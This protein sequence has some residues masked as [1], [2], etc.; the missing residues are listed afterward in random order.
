MKYVKLLLL[1]LAASS[2]KAQVRFQEIPL[3]EALKQASV[4]GKIVFAQFVSSSCEQCNEVADKAFANPQLGNLVKEKCIAIKIEPEAKDR[5][6]FMETYGIDQSMGSFFIT[7]DGDL[8]HRVNSTSSN[9]K[10]YTTAIET[11]YNKFVEGRLSLKELDNLWASTTND[12][13]LMEM[14]LKRR[15]ELSLPMD[16]L[17]EVYVSRLPADSL[18]SVRTLQFIAKQAPLLTSNASK[19]LRKDTSLFKEAWYSMSLQERVGIN[20]RIVSKTKKLAIA[21]KNI[22]IAL[23]AAN[24]ARSVQENPSSGGK[25]VFDFH[26]L[27]YYRG[28]K[29]KENLLVNAVAYCDNY[30]MKATV[31]QVRMMDSMY[32]RK[33]F[34]KA[35]A[36]TVRKGSGNMTIRKTAMVSLSPIAQDYCN[37]LGH[38]AE[39]IYNYSDDVELLKKAQVYAEKAVLIYENP[40]AI[41]VYAKILYANKQVEEA[42]KWEQK[43]IDILQQRQYTGN[44][45]IKVLQKMKDGASLK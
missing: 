5:N 7:A 44:R 33:L 42:M 6:G 36:D 29:D 2:A 8:V 31:Q 15:T 14:N 1:L 13:A 25:K 35:V 17:L 3:D 16:S 11:A 39:E 28:I 20:N 32:K 12:F 19:Q 38:C 24:F 22:T 4:N 23:K 18:V 45:F 34:E 43:A 27:G 26:M 21:T 10:L 37:A 30:Y 40:D 9:P 41:N